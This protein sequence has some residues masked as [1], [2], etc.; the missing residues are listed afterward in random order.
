MKKSVVTANYVTRVFGYHPPQPFNWGQCDRATQEQF[1]SPRW[2]KEWAAICQ[3]TV[4]VNAAESIRKLGKHIWHVHWK[5][6]T[7]RGAV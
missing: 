2:Q 1:S 7:G 3:E 5:D 4:D 6:M